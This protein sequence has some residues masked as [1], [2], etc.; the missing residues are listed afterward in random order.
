[1]SWASQESSSVYLFVSFAFSALRGR[2]QI[3]W[4]FAQSRRQLLNTIVS[5]ELSFV[6]LK[7]AWLLLWDEFEALS[8]EITGFSWK[9]TRFLIAG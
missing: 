8:A 7:Y 4:F 3:G 6:K 2:T 9:E 5:A 1:M